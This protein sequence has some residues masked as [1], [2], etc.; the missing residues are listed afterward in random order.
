[1]TARQVL[2]LLP[3]LSG[4]VN[5]GDH[6]IDVTR[7]RV[8]AGVTGDRFAH[9]QIRPDRDVLQYQLDLL[10]QTDARSPASSTSTRSSP[11]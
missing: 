4:Q 5:Q 1:M 6:F 9:R 2:N 7:C 3:L 10:T 11:R 8:I